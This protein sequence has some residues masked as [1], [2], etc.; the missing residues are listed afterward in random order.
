MLKMVDCEHESRLLKN[1]LFSVCA[2]LSRGFS[3]AIGSLFFAE[4]GAGGCLAVR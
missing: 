1:V 2:R 4:I 3:R